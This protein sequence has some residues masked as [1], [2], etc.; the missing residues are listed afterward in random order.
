MSFQISREAPAVPE[1]VAYHNFT[2]VKADIKPCLLPPSWCILEVCDNH[3]TLGKTDISKTFI[4]LKIQINADFS[5]A[6]FVFGMQ[7]TNFTDTIEHVRVRKYL[8][9]LSCRMVCP[10]VTDAELQRFADL[11]DPAVNQVYFRQARAAAGCVRSAKCLL[12]AQDLRCTECTKTRRLLVKKQTRALSQRPLSKHDPMHSTNKRV[13]THIKKNR[14]E[15]KV[16]QQEIAQLKK[17]R[18]S[19]SE[20]VPVNNELSDSLAAVVESTGDD[21]KLAK[22]F[23]EEQV[24]AFGAARHGMRW[25]PML[26]RLA[27]LIQSRSPLAYDTLRNT[28]ILKLPGKSTLRDYTNAIQPTVG[29]SASAIE[30]LK[31][32]SKDLKDSERYVVLL[33]DEMS[34]K[35]DLV[36]DKRSGEVVGFVNS[37]RWADNHV[38]SSSLAKHVLCFFVVGVNTNISVS[39]GHFGTCNATAVDMY[40]LFWQAVGHLE[41]QCGLR[42]IASVSDKASANQKLC[43]LHQT[44]QTDLPCYRTE[45]LYADRFIY[46]I[47]D[48][49][50][51]IKTVRNNLSNSGSGRNTQRL[52]C[53][54]KELL[55][56]HVRQLY[57]FDCR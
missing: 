19:L 49:P 28:G 10:G 16:L 13:T 43:E 32:L 45:N 57:E 38:T 5:I 17:F 56:K 27:I 18:D 26:I 42:V 33:H 41:L 8:T 52:W 48:P 4:E 31:R 6:A 39:L 51:L 53:R 29:F 34:I 20:S 12:F 46:F 35:A 36:Y 47:S 14:K 11:H 23:W 44:Q 50:H 55:W 2:E 9:D 15:M 25:H 1:R 54:G 3:I 37:D 40:P 7:V 30:E 24:K 21:N 22:L